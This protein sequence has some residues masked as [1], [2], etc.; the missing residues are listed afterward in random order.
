MNGTIGGLRRSLR[1]K[2]S[3]S[4]PSAEY[5]SRCS[6]L[7]CGGRTGADGGCTSTHSKADGGDWAGKTSAIRKEA[8]EGLQ[9]GKRSESGLLEPCSSSRR[10]E[11]PRKMSE[12]V[13][14]K[15]RARVK[16]NK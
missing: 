10:R 5:L 14:P 16:M 8:A 1:P 6:S 4:R 11:K 13:S 2:T 3:R 7:N 15:E 9:P 12:G